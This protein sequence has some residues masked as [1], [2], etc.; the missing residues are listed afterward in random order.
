MRS[1]HTFGSVSTKWTRRAAK[2]D[3][4][5]GAG[6]VIVAARR[7]YGEMCAENTPRASEVHGHAST[8]SD[9]TSV[10]AI[11]DGT[12]TVSRTI[13]Y[14]TGQRQRVSRKG[15]QTGGS[16][17]ITCINRRANPS[18]SIARDPTTN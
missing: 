14:D 11:K 15:D 13:H 7:V 17:P 6:R 1:F 5:H 12:H 4:W 16:E 10:A 3:W 18:P 9:A 2:T 8:A